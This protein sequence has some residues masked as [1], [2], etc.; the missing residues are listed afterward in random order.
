MNVTDAVERRISVRA[1][2]P[3]PVPGAVLTEILRIAQ[4]APSGG[5]LQPWLV[6]G[7]AGTP[8]AEFKALM[9]ARLAGPR[10]TPAY[11]VYPEALWDPYRTR[12]FE[13]GE[14]LYASLGIAREDKAGRL[15]Q[16]ARNFEF[17][18]AP[19]ALFFF[20]DRNMGPPQ[21]SDLGMYIQ[22]IMLL[23]VER[24]LDSCA[25]EAWSMWPQTVSAFLDVKEPYMLFC[26][27]AL[28]YRDE[29]HPVNG[30]RTRRAPLGEVAVLRGF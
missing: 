29:S 12:R 18:G 3:D 21:W 26:G 30:L 1:F 17:F 28:G 19:A 5:N 24:G 6:H 4:R 8:L 27:L 11:A 14:D 9:A 10:E 22:T 20:I 7:L 15:R 2:R 25:Q 13:T 23:A 16:F